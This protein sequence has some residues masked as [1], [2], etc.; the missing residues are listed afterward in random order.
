M[1]SRLM[2]SVVNQSFEPT[3]FSAELPK[4][5]KQEET[6]ADETLLIDFGDIFHRCFCCRVDVV[7]DGCRQEYLM[8]ESPNESRLLR[9]CQHEE[10]PLDE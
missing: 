10:S 8:K 3:F 1:L 9:L 2:K 4:N 7:V 5:R 6:T